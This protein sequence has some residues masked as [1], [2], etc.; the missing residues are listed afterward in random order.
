LTVASASSFS[1][2]NMM[3]AAS[4]ITLLLVPAQAAVEFTLFFGN[5]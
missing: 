3:R 1:C 2:T 5:K 4:L